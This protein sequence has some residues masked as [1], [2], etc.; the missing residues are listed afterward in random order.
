MK[1]AC[2]RSYGDVSVLNYEDIPNPAPGRGEIAIDVKAAALNHLDI[3]IRKGRPGLKHVFPHVLGS[4]ASGIVAELGEGVTN[5]AVGDAVILNPGVN[6]VEDEYTLRGEHSIST[7]Y[8]IMGQARSGTFAQRIVAP[9]VCAYPKPAHLTFEQAAAL[10]LAHLTAWRMLMSRAQLKPGETVLIHGIGGGV[11]IA[12]LQFARLASAECIVTSS[13]DAKLARAKELGACHTINYRSTPDVAAAV[14][15][16]TQ[17]RGVDVI[18]DSV[19]AGT[20]PINFAAA[21]K[22]GR[23]VHCGATSGMEATVNMA[24][25]YWS[26]LTIMGSTIGSHEEFRQMLQAVKASGLVPVIDQTFPLA[27]ARAA[28]ARMEAGDQFGKI[29]LSPMG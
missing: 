5:V 15:E 17:G 12:A 14:R 20:W 19:G 18:I 25:L 26:Q 13:S 4:D 9:A 24:A 28:Q 23:I 21:R 2:I 7:S 8:G 11:A 16:L 27:E 6:P 3:W 22:G 10:P 1:A 29:V